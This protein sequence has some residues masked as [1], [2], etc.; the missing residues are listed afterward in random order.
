MR[1][2][3]KSL[4][5]DRAVAAIMQA[6]RHSCFHCDAPGKVAAPTC[7]RRAPATDQPAWHPQGFFLT[8]QIK[9]TVHFCCS[10]TCCRAAVAPTSRAPWSN[11]R[12]RDVVCN[13]KNERFRRSD[14]RLAF[15]WLWTSFVTAPWHFCRCCAYLAFQNRSGDL[16]LRYF[17]KHL[18]YVSSHWWSGYRIPNMVV[19][20]GQFY[21]QGCT[22]VTTDGLLRTPT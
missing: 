19:G 3:I 2:R 1:I 11:I 14:M 7:T 21:R 4:S 8:Y 6:V 18:T 13:G 5:P 10:R 22:F 9:S 12:C 17:Y 16:N 20:V 15:L